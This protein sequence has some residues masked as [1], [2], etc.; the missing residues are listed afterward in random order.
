MYERL[1]RETEGA[2]GYRITRPLDAFEVSMIADEIEGAIE[3]SGAVRILIDLEAF[4]YQ[5]LAAH[6]EDLK[7]DVRYAG[8]ISKFALVG[9]G[10]LES[11]ATR[12][13]AL[14]TRTESRRFA[15][16]QTDAAWSWL[17][18]D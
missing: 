9:G 10:S 12:I 14:L 1:N 4:P 8:Q 3:Q 18:E 5:N 15:K 13:F 17:I 7:F 11:W 16:G 6:W 2:M